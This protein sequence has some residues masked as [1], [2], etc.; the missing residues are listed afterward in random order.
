MIWVSAAILAK[1][2]IDILIENQNN[3]PAEPLG[4]DL[5]RQILMR[6][7]EEFSV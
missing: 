1:A 2:V 5:T 3:L 6:Y 4:P 7:P